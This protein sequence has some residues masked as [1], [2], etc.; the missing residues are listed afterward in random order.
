MINRENFFSKMKG[1]NL[2]PVLLQ[3]QMDGIIRIFL[4]WN[5]TYGAVPGDL[6]WLAYMLA[7]AYH[8]TGRK[9]QPVSEKGSGRDLDH[10]GMDDYLEKYDTRTDL[11]NTPE[12]DG[13]G[14]RYAGKGLTQTTGK[15]NYEKLTKANNRNWNFIANPDL[16]LQPEPSIWAMFYAMTTGLYT[17]KKLSDYFNQNKCY[18]ISAR[19]IINGVDCAQKIAE[20]AQKFHSCLITQNT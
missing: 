14:V 12:V 18:W 8:E 4:E 20:Y 17:G 15:A 19:R 7:T 3:T 11:G 6:R 16:L 13:D 5:R 1:T 9:M 10:D 2:F